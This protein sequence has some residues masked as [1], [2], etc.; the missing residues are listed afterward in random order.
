VSL[1][2]WQWALAIVGG[3]CV[4]FSK[5]AVGGVGLVSVTIFA[6]LLPAKEA[7]GLV[8]PMLIC[9]DI[10]AV[11][12]YRQHTD[13]RQ[14]ARLLPWAAVGVFCGWLAMGRINDRQASTL[15]GLIVLAMV[16]LHL[17]RQRRERRGEGAP[18]VP[19]SFA[20]FIGIMAGF[21]SLVANAA[22]PLMALYFLAM[23][24]PKM[25]WMGTAA[26]YFI[27]M[28]LF[29]VPFMVQLD[30]INTGSLFANLLLLPAVLA[31]AY[32]GR[33]LLPKIDQKLFEALALWL[34][35]LAGLK[36]LF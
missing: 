2:L 1:E 33:W 7:S 34:S 4:G 20:A 21:T 9:A 5:T 23:R 19:T 31:G 25:K 29:K 18:E 36:L 35:V 17:W 28:N 22:G 6:N 14:L 3:L 30:L 26:V 11:K 15:I 13:W 24:F 27:V 32:F 10:V 12:S 8:L 16:G